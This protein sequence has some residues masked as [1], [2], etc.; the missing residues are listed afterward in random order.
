MGRTF[1][2][3]GAPDPG[4]ARPLPPADRSMPQKHPFIVQMGKKIRKIRIARGLK[5]GEVAEA[6]GVTRSYISAIETGIPNSTILV[7][8][9]L[10]H[11][12][13]VRLSDL[14]PG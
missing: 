9:R 8:Y 1:R 10:A 5:Q 13:K 7:L 14:L 6:I 11:L 12:F 4:G 2:M 3:L